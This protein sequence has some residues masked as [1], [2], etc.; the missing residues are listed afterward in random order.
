MP[1][2]HTC[3]N[4]HTHTHMHTLTHTCTHSHTHAHTHTHMHALTH[5]HTHTHMQTNGCNQ[6][7]KK[8]PTTCMC[9]CSYFGHEMGGGQGSCAWTPGHLKTSLDRSKGHHNLKGESI[10]F[11][12]SHTDQI[13]TPRMVDT[14]P[15]AGTRPIQAVNKYTTGKRKAVQHGQCVDSVT[16]TE[17]SLLILR[18]LS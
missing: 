8:G 15:V 1:W 11:T 6:I 16:F 14:E 18:G 17:S 13:V 4:I 3:A 12:K 9:R 7:K 2:S 5:S 10:F